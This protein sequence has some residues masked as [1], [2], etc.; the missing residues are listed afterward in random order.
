MI[1]LRPYQQNAFNL[2]IDELS[3][4]D[5]CSIIM[6]CG[7]GKSVLGASIAKIFNNAVVF[8]PTIDLITQL[9]KDYMSVGFLKKEILPVCSSIENEHVGHLNPSRDPKVIKDH[10]LNGG[11]VICTYASYDVIS[12]VTESMT[13]HLVIYDE[14]HKISGFIDKSWAKSLFD[15]KA[16]KRIFMTATQKR[17]H[18]K[19][20]DRVASMDNIRLFGKV[21][22]HLPM[23]E[24]IEMGYICDYR[25]IISLVTNSEI[26]DNLKETVIANEVEMNN[27]SHSDEYKK[28]YMAKVK[29]AVLLIAMEDA[30][31]KWEIK[32]IITFHNTVKLAKR[33][34]GWDDLLP[35]GF[36]VHHVNGYMSQTERAMNINTLRTEDKVVVSCAKLL[37]EGINVPNC[38]LAV[39]ADPRNSWLDIT[40]I[41]GRVVRLH[42]DKEFGYI[43]IPLIVNEDGAL[44]KDS[45]KKL[46]D[47]R[48]CL[49]ELR[50]SD[51]SMID[52]IPTDMSDMKAPYT[53]NGDSKIIIS[54]T[55]NISLNELRKS[56][57][58][59]IMEPY[60]TFDEK[61]DRQ[62]QDTVDFLKENNKLP[63]EG[64]KLYSWLMFQKY[65]FKKG[66][67]L[68]DRYQMLL[69]LGYVFQDSWDIMFERY[70]IS[71]EPKMADDKELK[72]WCQNQRIFFK[73]GK[74]K[75]EREEILREIGFRLDVADKKIRKY[76][77]TNDQFDKFKEIYLSGELPSIIDS[78]IK[79]WIITQRKLYTSGLMSELRIQQYKDLGDLAFNYIANSGDLWERK[80][81][82]CRDIVSKGLPIPKKLSSWVDSQRKL[83]RD[84]NVSVDRIKLLNKIGIDG[85]RNFAKL[86]YNNRTLTI[87]EWA[88]IVNIRQ[89]TIQS[90]IES[91]WSV[92]KALTTS[93]R[94][95]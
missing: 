41:L 68:D 77:E 15:V 47:I 84:Q 27:T 3:N 43:M 74:L 52:S 76:D 16:N 66:K 8:V 26:I 31:K 67:L 73:A 62:Y 2:T 36:K 58:S 4:T 6:A 55:S 80:Y 65:Q 28:R 85:T 37:S 1:A 51:E 75:K 34:I 17:Y 32:K 87:A 18:E 94:A 70:K 57:F 93:V 35:N 54:S 72:F 24:A 71:G 21:V 49:R 25:I 81:L 14:A 13:P 38:D 61:W 59:K 63:E 45:E 91:G 46:A 22:Y 53:D 69:K 33:I 9:R 88:K 79:T 29:D 78:P 82:Q 56:V 42:E 39:L 44:E 12:I 19:Y 40:Q 5:R 95:R 92:E 11:I 60:E 7:T 90:R 23:K 30:I 50:E 64:D 89:Q 10:L 83:I 20:G 48:R 86:T